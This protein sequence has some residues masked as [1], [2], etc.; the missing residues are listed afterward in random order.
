MWAAAGSSGNGS[1]TGG[2]TEEKAV[3]GLKRSGEAEG[4]EDVVE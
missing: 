2:V 3:E 1:D 4:K